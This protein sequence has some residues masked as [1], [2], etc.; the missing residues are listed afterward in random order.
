MKEKP[1]RWSV[2][3]GTALL[4]AAGFWLRSRQMETGAVLPLAAVSLLA[5]ALFAA[6][7]V[8]S[9]PRPGY[10]ENFPPSTPAMNALLRDLPSSHAI[11]PPQMP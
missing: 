10:G 2:L 7:A 5:V 4:S 3:A 6:A 9:R 8:F 11:T 1:G